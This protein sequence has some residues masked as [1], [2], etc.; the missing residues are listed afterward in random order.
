MVVRGGGRI[1]FTSSIAA[2]QPGPF[3]AAY[4]ASKAFLLSFSEALGNEL[5]DS[6]ITVT[7]L[8]PGPTDTEF[9]E[10]AG[11]SKLAPEAVKAQLHRKMAEPG[12]GSD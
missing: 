11:A 1:L 6:G 4:A 8:M 12:S 7:A 10:R 3:E 2:A 5:K 9:F